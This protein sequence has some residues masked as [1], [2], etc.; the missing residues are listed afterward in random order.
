MNTLIVYDSLYGNTEKI[1]KAIAKGIPEAKLIN[2]SKTGSDSLK[3]IDLLIV[4]SPTQGGRPTQAL[5]AFLEAIPN[6]SLKNTKVAAFDTRFSEKNSG[7]ILKFIIKTFGYAA[8]KIGQSL[9]EKG[10][11]SIKAPE[12]FIVTGKSG[13]LLTGELERANNWF[14][15]A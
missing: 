5:Q 8:D 12:G 14:S 10:G 2:V 11:K 3:D 13:P 15:G 7:L 9:Q 1:A 4:G 6:S